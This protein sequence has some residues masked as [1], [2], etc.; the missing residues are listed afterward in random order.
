VR[1][2]GKAS[3]LEGL[4]PESDQYSSTV[5]K[6]EGLLQLADCSKNACSQQLLV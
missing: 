2:S 4:L 3:D 6:T 1:F 5:F